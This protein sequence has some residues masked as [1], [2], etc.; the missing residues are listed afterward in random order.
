MSSRRPINAHSLCLLFILEPSR[1]TFCTMGKTED[2]LLTRVTQDLKTVRSLQLDLVSPLRAH[3]RL[4]SLSR[5]SDHLPLPLERTRNKRKRGEEVR[6][7]L[8]PLNQPWADYSVPAANS[9][10][11]TRRTRVHAIP[12][13][14]SPERSSLGSQP[15]WT[16]M[17]RV[18]L[19]L[20][21][22][23]KQ[24]KPSGWAWSSAQRRTSK[25]SFVLPP[26]PLASISPSVELSWL[27][28]CAT[29]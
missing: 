3:T 11:S 1:D 8:R 5:S 2:L 23:A 4:S 25:V 24:L 12:P 21:Q 7:L 27:T 10:S 13:G 15:T 9:P 19:R 22:T 14:S 29:L 16:W 6:S 26:S 17:S 28:L 20:L 18:L